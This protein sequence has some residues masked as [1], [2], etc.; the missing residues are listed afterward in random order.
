MNQKYFHGRSY[1]RFSQRR[2][3]QFNRATASRRPFG[4]S[5]DPAKFINKAVV[6]TQEETFVPQNRFSDFGLNQKLLA[7]IL[8]KG[9]EMPT[10]IQDKVIPQIKKGLDV[11]GVAN[12]GTGKTGAFLIPLIEK[13]IRNPREKVLILAPTR[14]L[15]LQINQEFKSF[16]RGIK[17]YSASC[18]G[19]A[20]IFTQLHELKYANEFVIGTPGRI[21]DL[22][23]RKALNLSYFSTIVLDEADRMLDMGFINDTREIISSMPK[24]RHTLFFSATMGKEV[25]SLINEFLHNPVIVLAKTAETPESIE[26]D[27]VKVG[28]SDKVEILHSLLIKE[29]FQKILIFGRTK[30]SVERLSKNLRARGFSVESIHGNKTHGKRQRALEAFK[31]DAVKILVATDIAA[32]GLDIPEVTHVI[33]FDVPAT[34][35]DYIHRIGRTGRANK[36]GKALTFV[37]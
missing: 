21:K 11:V 36:R 3:R 20:S 28:S 19:G 7:N 37:S 15:A 24:V 1:N 27:V 5:I 14:E 30:F 2:S 12:T 25:E 31:K 10:R 16:V 6:I 33:N 4:Q 8:A 17:M 35:E 22:I 29:E 13:V 32:R 34:Y 26:Q 9:Y 18:V 23:Q